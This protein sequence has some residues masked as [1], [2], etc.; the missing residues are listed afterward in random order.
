[1]GGK[2]SDPQ[3][4]KQT[5]SSIRLMRSVQPNP[6]D[7]AEIAHRQVSLFLTTRGMNIVRQMFGGDPCVHRQETSACLPALSAA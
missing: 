1:M 5:V 7:G 2:V 6:L 4:W 3:N